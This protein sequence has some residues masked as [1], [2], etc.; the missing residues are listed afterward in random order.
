MPKFKAPFVDLVGL[1]FDSL[2]YG[3]SRCHLEIDDRHM[4]T[5]GIVH[6][7]VLF[8]MAD[9]GMGAAVTST[10]EPGERCATIEVKISYLSTVHKGEVVCRSTVTH[11]TGNFAFIESDLIQDDAV[12]ARATGTFVLSKR[13]VST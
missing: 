13:P 1:Q 7:G 11:K 9:T 12:I 8:T 5:N 2:E 6:G 4:N 10:L 3:V